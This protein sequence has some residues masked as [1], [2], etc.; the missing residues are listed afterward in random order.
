MCRGAYGEGE[1]L[2][3][4][5]TENLA[6]TRIQ[7]ALDRVERGLSKYLRL[8]NQIRSCDVSRTEE[9]QR[10]FSGFY[11]VRRNSRWKQEYFK[12]MEASKLTGIDFP[13]ALKEINL[14]CGR[15][16]A[17]FASKLVATLDSSMP[18]IDKFVLKFFG[19]RL[20]R[21]GS[22]GREANIIDLIAVRLKVEKN[23]LVR[24][25]E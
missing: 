7:I 21:W 10:L 19:L 1:A 6:E 24:A 18:V 20:P 13:E 12:L 8:Q 5:L 3:G 15:V 16:E 23:Q 2:I 17:S 4:E 14:R 22:T 11:R 9:F 25:I